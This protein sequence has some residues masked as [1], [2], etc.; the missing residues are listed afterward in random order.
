M[1]EPNE[2]QTDDLGSVIDTLQLGRK[3]GVLIV[4]REDTMK[5]EVGVIT[6]VNGQITRAT[7]GNLGTAEAL[8]WLST[9]KNC[10]FSFSPGIP[11]ETSP[12]LFRMSGPLPPRQTS[13]QRALPPATPSVQGSPTW[14]GIRRIK[15]PAEALQ[16]IEQYGLSRTHRRLFLLLDAQRTISELAVLVRRSPEEVHQMLGQLETLGLI[17]R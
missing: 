6:F 15:H 12:T 7:L 11:P 16:I 4:K 1:F 9:W 8:R 14:S 5:K 13:R 3:S 2:T 10:F 17:Q